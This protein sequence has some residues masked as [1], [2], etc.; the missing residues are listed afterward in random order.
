VVINGRGPLGTTLTFEAGK[1]YLLRVANVGT[2]ASLNFRIEGH[3]MKLV[4]TEGSHTSQVTYDN[5]DVHVGQSY[6]VLV[7]MD[8]APGDYYIV[9]STRFAKPTL[10]GV[11]VLHY[12]SSPQSSKGWS[13]S[14]LPRPLPAGP[15]TEIDRS[16]T[17]ARSIRWNLTANAARPNPQG[18]FHYGAIGVS[19]TVVLS[20]SGATIGGKLRY[21]VNGLSYVPPAGNTPLKLADYFN[22]SGG[23]F[24]LG[25]MPDAAP[26]AS[27]APR[28]ATPVLS[29][30]HRSFVEI[31]FQNPA[32]VVDSWHIDGYSFFV[33]G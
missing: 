30:A 26:P 4:E 23:T 10:N 11:A 32:N 22:I 13:M 12:A 21:A 9:A 33:V 2:S 16:L 25:S 17:Q 1:T 20:S 29:A 6:S 3:K 19:R 28:L 18:S 7:T 31:V 24:S 14:R 5:L 8:Q 15:T 27:T